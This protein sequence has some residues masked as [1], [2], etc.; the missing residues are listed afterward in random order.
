MI[1]ALTMNIQESYQPMLPLSPQKGPDSSLEISPNKKRSIPGN[2]L[3]P[4]VWDE[5]LMAVTSQRKKLIWE[6]N[7]STLDGQSRQREAETIDE[8]PNTFNTSKSNV[9]YSEVIC[10]RA[11]TL[12]VFSLKKVEINTGWIDHPWSNCPTDY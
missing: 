11:L 2:D 10:T 4:Q 5:P 9:Q 12:K 6:D 7:Y 1:K 3:C 8:K